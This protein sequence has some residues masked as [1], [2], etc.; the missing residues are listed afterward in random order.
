[1][2]DPKHV[3]TF[4]VRQHIVDVANYRLPTTLGTINLLSYLK[5][6][7]LR[8][9]AVDVET[10]R[11]LW[12]LEVCTPYTWLMSCM[13]SFLVAQASGLSPCHPAI[14]LLQAW[15]RQLLHDNGKGNL[16][17]GE[18]SH[19][20]SASVDSVND[21]RSVASPTAAAQGFSPTAASFGSDSPLA[22][23]GTS[24]EAFDDRSID[25][26]VCLWMCCA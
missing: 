24:N 19:G 20:A 7:P 26:P 5:G 2:F 4:H 17:E 13:P 3:F 11:H 23:S 8:F 22:V 12:N 10:Q 14:V 6:Q 9:M 16:G 15:H 21:V 25:S 18:S 1:M